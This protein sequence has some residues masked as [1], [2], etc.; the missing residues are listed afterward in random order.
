MG[1][2]RRYKTCVF[3]SIHS[4]NHITIPIPTNCTYTD[5]H[6][7]TCTHTQSDHYYQHG[8]TCY[9]HN[10]YDVTYFRTTHKLQNGSYTQTHLTNW[11]VR[12]S[13]MVTGNYRLSYLYN[14]Y[15][16]HHCLDAFGI[17]FKEVKAAE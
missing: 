13:Q 16:W 2:H 15:T 11:E 17:Q 9:G 7:H 3:R 4:H 5:T 14:H 10:P 1:Y 8:H 12:Q 6:T